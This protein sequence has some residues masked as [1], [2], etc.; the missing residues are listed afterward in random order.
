MKI[1]TI[2]NSK[3]GVGKSTLLSN[4]IYKSVEMNYNVILADLDKQKSLEKWNKKKLKIRKVDTADLNKNS[5]KKLKF[6]FLF[7]DTQAAIRKTR[8]NEIMNITDVV[9]V[10]SSDSYIDL[11]AT[12][13]FLYRIEKYNKNKIK[14]LAVLNKIRFSNKIEEILMK[15]EGVLK[16]KI[17]AFFPMS[18][19][20]DIQMSLGSTIL[21][22]NYAQVTLINEQLLNII[23]KF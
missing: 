21:K 23:N 4:L 12:K 15:C 20:F 1:I 3:G 19:K 9:I 22:S 18:K 17:T 7:I 16:R 5:R 8:L 2:V 6:D 14:I 11:V 10:P 13:R